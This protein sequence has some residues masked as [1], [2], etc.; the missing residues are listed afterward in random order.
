MGRRQ[1]FALYSKPIML[2]IGV[3]SYVQLVEYK[4][5]N[6][7]CLV[8]SRYEENSKLGKWV[9]TQVRTNAATKKARVEAH[10]TY[11]FFVELLT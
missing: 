5:T 1:S 10:V 3:S 8:P 2:L 4:E 9:E 11:A 6:G 7:H